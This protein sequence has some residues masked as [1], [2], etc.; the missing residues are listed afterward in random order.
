VRRLIVIGVVAS[1]FVAAMAIPAS[2][3][4]PTP[5][6]GSVTFSDDNPCTPIFDLEEHEI[7][8]NFEGVF[9]EHENSYV[10]IAKATGITD[11]GFVMNHSS[12]SFVENNN[13]ASGAFKDLWRHPDGSK[14]I[15]Q[16]HFIFN[17]NTGELLV[18]SFRL[19]CVG[20]N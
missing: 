13:V 3:D 5:F 16:G 9:H 12:S 18:D 1:M 8:I 19:R 20:N 4:Q 6:S 15:A 14:F 10:E 11:S 7:T 2:A 17:G